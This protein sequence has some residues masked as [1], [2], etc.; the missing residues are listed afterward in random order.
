MTT[1][2]THTMTATEFDALLLREAIAR[3][4]RAE[5]SFAHGV[6][7]SVIELVETIS[8]FRKDP[9]H[10]R[11]VLFSMVVCKKIKILGPNY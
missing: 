7:E 9:D 8:D 5:S 3:V 1:M 6:N 11:E 4:E 2:P 10:H